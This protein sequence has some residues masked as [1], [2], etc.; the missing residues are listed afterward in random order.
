MAIREMRQ[1]PADIKHAVSG[2]KSSVEEVRRDIALAE[3]RTSIPPPPQAGWDRAPDRIKVRITSEAEV[4][5]A[6]LEGSI[7]L[8]LE[9]ADVEVRDAVLEAP[10]GVE[11]SSKWVLQLK[12]EAR[13]AARRAGN[14]VEQLRGPG[15]WWDVSVQLSSGGAERI[16]ICLDNN[17]NTV[18]VHQEGK[19]HLE[20]DVP[21]SHLVPAAA[22]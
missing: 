19:G 9:G 18:R 20:Q 2:A 3:A 11:F 10:V 22:G 5:L 14:L 12:G 13:K 7:R 15:G 6:H 21:P 16:C 1:Q 8:F 17:L 4:A